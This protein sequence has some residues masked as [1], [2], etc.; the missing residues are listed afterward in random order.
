MAFLVNNTRFR[1]IA[2]DKK[3]PQRNK[4]ST[5]ATDF[6]ETCVFT[7]KDGKSS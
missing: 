3:T 2:V 1:H 6:S 7:Y 4:K 5:H